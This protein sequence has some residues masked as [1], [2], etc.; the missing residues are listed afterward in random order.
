MYVHNS[1]AMFSLETLPPGG[2]RTRVLLFLRGMTTAPRRYGPIL[3]RYNFW[4]LKI[5]NWETVWVIARVI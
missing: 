1:I 5:Q 2:I 4:Q 3:K